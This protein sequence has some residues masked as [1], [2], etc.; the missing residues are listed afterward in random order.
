MATAQRHVVRREIVE[1]AFA[2]D[3]SDGFAFQRT[4]AD[5]C[6]DRLTRA[7]ENAFDETVPSDEHWSI[8]R[9]AVDAGSFSIAALERDFI[10]AVT[11]GVRR[12]IGDRA[13]GLGGALSR[14][15]SPRDA[16][17]ATQSP[18]DPESEA[19][20]ASSG[21]LQ[22]RTEPPRDARRATQ[23]PFHAESDSSGASSD[24]LQRRSEREA[25]WDAFFHFLA[26]GALPWWFRL[27]HRSSLE[28]AV[29]AFWRTVA[30]PARFGRDL[31]R[32]IASPVMR[33]RL[34]RQFSPRSLDSLLESVSPDGARSVRAIL[35]EID[36]EGYP[37]A[38]SRLFE[39]LWETAFAQAALGGRMTVESVATEWLDRLSAGKSEPERRLIA[40]IAQAWPA[41]RSE[42][43]SANEKSPAEAGRRVPASAADSRKTRGEDAERAL[44]ASARRLDLDEGVFVECAGLV[45]LHPF[46]PR[47]FDVLGIARDGELVHYDRALCVLHFLATGERRAPEYALVLAKRLCNLPLEEPA[48]APVALSSEEEAEAIALLQAVIAHWDALGGTSV[49]GLRGTFLVRAGKLSRRGEDDVLQVER[50]S[51]DVLLDKLPWGIGV[52]RLPWMTSMLWVEWTS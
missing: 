9:L 13:T 15:E 20:G 45:I 42:D 49:D 18:F 5:L 36:R 26:T 2:G 34:V 32:A 22:R 3:E 29:G 44:T 46:L 14:T 38:A 33:T 16:R 10:D 4:F 6:R 51:F 50:G 37:E 12:Q 39:P 7:L 43:G 41:M 52:V 23:S 19:S 24:S 48:P 30:Q 1:V 8:D 25:L 28:E 31:A 17:R 11:E 27:P 47:L 40:R 35:R 21:P